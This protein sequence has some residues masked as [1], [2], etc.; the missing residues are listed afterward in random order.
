[1]LDSLR[2]AIRKRRIIHLR[3][4]PGLRLIE[5]YVVGYGKDGRL[6]LKAFQP[7]GA[8]HL[9]ERPDWKLF[10]L[11]TCSRIKLTDSSFSSP[12]SDY[13]RID[14][15]MRGGIIARL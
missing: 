9:G 1:M 2:I 3:Y 10:L 4:C 13:I 12:R 14:N 5:P 6:L 8:S 11:E 7:G 15:A